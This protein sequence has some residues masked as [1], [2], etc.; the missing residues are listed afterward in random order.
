[1]VM[2]RQASRSRLSPR[3]LR[4]RW[5]T[6]KQKLRLAAAAALA[7]LLIGE[8][9]WLVYR[10]GGRYHPPEPGFVR[11]EVW[12]KTSDGVR[13]HAWFRPCPPA[14]AAPYSERLAVIYFHGTFGELTW[15]QGIARDWQ[16]SLGYDVLL[17][18]NRGYGLSEGQPS[19]EGLYRDARAAFYWL[20]RCHGMPPA[21]VVLVGRSLGGAVALELAVAAQLRA[22]V[23]ESTF[24][25]LPEVAEEICFGLPV[26]PLMAV[27]G[28]CW[29]ASA[30]FNARSW[31]CTGA[32]T[33]SSRQSMPRISTRPQGDRRDCF[34]FPARDTMTLRVRTSTRRCVKL[35]Q[36]YP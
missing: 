5:R 13:L 26:G 34:S 27:F 23:L 21:R 32:K 1:M 22:V 7:V 20:T 12:V 35:L 24:T 2:V 28:R 36:D 33:P 19:E 10:R 25:S 16:K 31:S 8:E 17:F 9:D 30:L 29:S 14:S 11:Q 4:R 15:R 18:D 3:K 6:A